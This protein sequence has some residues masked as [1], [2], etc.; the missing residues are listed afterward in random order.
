MALS[1]IEA[2]RLK[3]S[4]K[5]IITREEAVGDGDATHF[6]LGHQS[7]LSSPNI[8]VRK[9]GAVISTG[10][11]VNY[12]NG[13]VDFTAA[14]LVT[15]E[16]EFTYYWSIFTDAEVQYFI[17]EAGNNITIATARLLL[18][19][20][21][22]ASKVAQRQSLAGGGGLGAVTLDTSV[23]ARE[24]RN[25]A[26]AL[27]QME[28]QISETVPAEGLTELAWTEFQYRQGVEQDLIRNN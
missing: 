15:D 27:V 17:D 13:I 14:P 21:A 23:T 28:G 18:A 2:V 8:E 6:K 1:D 7:I 19:I 9:N 10:F 4:D 5:S 12:V 20:A 16:L 24:L 22:D 3:S 11:T 25:T 26:A